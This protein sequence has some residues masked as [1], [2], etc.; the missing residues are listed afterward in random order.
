MT[1]IMHEVKLRWKG[2]MKFFTEAPGGTIVLDTVPAVG[3]EDDG[4]RPKPLM[5]VSLGGCTAM[6][7]A[8]LMKKMRVDE[9]VRDFRVIV[10]GELT[11]KHPKYYRSVAVEYHFHGKNL[12]RQRLTKAVN[13]SIERY[14]GV[15]H[16]FKH[17]ADFQH[18]IVFHEE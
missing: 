11:D 13:L 7:V 14:C 6:D 1:H 17:F 18:E 9:A 10:R 5:L 15:I 3:G 2:K 4:L 12:D 16:M 8:S